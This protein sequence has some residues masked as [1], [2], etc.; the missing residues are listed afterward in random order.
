MPDDSPAAV[1]VTPCEISI[2]I[3]GLPHLILR[4]SDLAGIQ[5]Y[6]K[7]V[8]VRDPVYFI[9]FSMRTGDIIADY[10]MRTLWEQILVALRD[11]RIF[12][13]MQGAGPLPGSA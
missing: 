7:T 4:R 13:N 11:S 2:L 5:S 8:G 3:R 12:D 1:Q 10:D 6:I 9:E